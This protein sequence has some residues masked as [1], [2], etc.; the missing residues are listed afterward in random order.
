MKGTEKTNQKETNTENKK[1]V[2]GKQAE[3][4]ERG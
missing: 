3:E 4:R 2:K 1:E